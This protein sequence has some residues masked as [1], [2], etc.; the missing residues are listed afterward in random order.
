MSKFVLIFA[1]FFSNENDF[2]SSGFRSTA[3]T[4]SHQLLLWL[5]RQN[6]TIKLNKFN[7]NLPVNWNR[8]T[9]Y[10]GFCSHSLTHKLPV[11]SIVT[12]IMCGR[13]VHWS[14]SMAIWILEKCSRVAVCWPEECSSKD[15]FHHRDA[16]KSA[17]RRCDFIAEEGS[18]YT[19][20]PIIFISKLLPL[21]ADMFASPDPFIEHGKY[22]GVISME[23]TWIDWRQ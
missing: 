8:W 18:R 14:F 15:R 17:W 4:R 3:D 12:N 1:L 22:F 23:N 11:A 16:L 13:E 20:F 9:S 5:F 6:E 19:F 7:K 2:G 21:F 10:G